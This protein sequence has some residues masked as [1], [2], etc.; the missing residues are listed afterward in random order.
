MSELWNEAGKLTERKALSAVNQELHSTAVGVEVVCP[1]AD[2]T[3]ANTAVVGII[4]IIWCD[5]SE[6]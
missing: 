3:S 2:V 5:N 4:V 1:E 6:L